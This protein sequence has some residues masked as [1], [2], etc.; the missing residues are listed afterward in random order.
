MT[1]AQAA[2]RPMAQ[3]SARSR[4]QTQRNTPGRQLVLHETWENST[5]RDRMM[6]RDTQSST[7][8]STTTCFLICTSRISGCIPDYWVNQLSI[9]LSFGPIRETFRTQIL[10]YTPLTRPIHTGS[11]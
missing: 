4:A 11:P 8:F 1:A 5:S 10:V 6:S 9:L 7:Q 2:A 3:T